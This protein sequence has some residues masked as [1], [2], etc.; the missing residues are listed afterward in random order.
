MNSISYRLRHCPQKKQDIL[1]SHF[2]NE[3][4]FLMPLT[5]GGYLVI[6]NKIHPIRRGTLFVMQE[7]TL[8]HQVPPT[9]PYDRFILQID[10]QIVLE[11]STPRTD[12]SKY[13]G[14]GSWA[15]NISEKT[16][17]FIELFQAMQDCSGEGFGGDILQIHR[18]QELMLEVCRAAADGVQIPQMPTAGAK[19]I[20]RIMAIQ[21]YIQEHMTEQITLDSLS[22]QFYISKYYLSHLFKENTDYGIIEYVNYCR[23]SQASHLLRT[24]V[25]ASQVGEQVGFR[26]QEHF[27]RTFKKLVGMTPNQ[28]YTKFAAAQPY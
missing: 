1:H 20:Q 5:D 18:C 21:N 22:K 14:T 28:Y 24:G 7:H 3:I 26:S 9:K 13:L 25:A 27:I 15:L 8:H 19:D 23:I 16:E 6:D 11:L 10:P 4:E 17:R 12:F 2:H